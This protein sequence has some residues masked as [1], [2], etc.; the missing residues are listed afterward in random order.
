MEPDSMKRLAEFIS[1]HYGDDPDRLALQ[2]DKWP[3]IDVAAAVSTLVSRKKLVGKAPLW[4]STEGLVLPRTLSAEQ[5]SSEAAARHKAALIKNIWSRLQDAAVSVGIADVG[6]DPAFRKPRIADLTGGLGVDSLEFSKVSEAVLYNEMNP[7]LAE[8]A[9]HNFLILG[10][11]NIEVCSFCADSDSL[12]PN[13]TAINEAQY[14]EYSASAAKAS[15]GALSSRLQVFRPDVIFLDPARRDICGKKV[16]LLEDCSPD[17]LELKDRLLEI[18]PVLMV[19]LSPMADISMVIDRLGKDCRELQIIESQGECKELLAVLVRN[20]ISLSEATDNQGNASS[21]ECL[22]S[23]VN[24]DTDEREPYF[25]FRRSDESSSTGLQFVEEC[26]VVPGALLFEP[27]KAMMK[28]GCFRLLGKRL[29]ASVFGRDTHY[30]VLSK[31]LPEHTGEDIQIEDESSKFIES[32]GKLFRI[33]DLSPLSGKGIKEFGRRHQEAE[34]TARGV[35]MSSEE[36]RKRLGCR[37]SE[38]YHIFALHADKSGRNLLFFCE[39]SS[40]SEY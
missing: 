21:D 35:K 11:E 15:A 16:F 39:K 3:E 9:E 27:G 34:V 33:I 38:R 7:S 23:I 17:I 13:D 12:S 37:P 22:C 36:L 18:A 31:L 10:A 14:A 4:A 6:S 30:Y 8:A 26:V 20:G 40:F 2:K 29:G 1:A 32:A 28:A 24:L 19:K 25:R 5:C